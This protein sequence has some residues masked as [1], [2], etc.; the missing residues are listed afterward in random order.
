MIRTR[1]LRHV[2]SLV[3]TAAVL[4]LK[5]FFV[6]KVPTYAVLQDLCFL[7]VPIFNYVREREVERS[8]TREF[9]I[10]EGVTR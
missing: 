5:V 7:C 9:N 6:L 10:G 3:G 8:E 2:M 4:I 1:N